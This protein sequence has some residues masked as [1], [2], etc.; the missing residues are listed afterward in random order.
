MM[1]RQQKAVIEDRKQAGL[2]IKLKMDELIR[3]IKK[4]DINQFEELIQEDANLAHSMFDRVNFPIHIACEFNRLS[5]VKQL[6]EIHRV[7]VNVRCKLTGYS[8]LMYACQVGNYDIIE[9]LSL[10]VKEV[11][12]ETQSLFGRNAV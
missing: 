2:M 6:V 8:P 4:N 1:S 5:M 7:D 12:L 3:S 10:K 9:Y 11:D